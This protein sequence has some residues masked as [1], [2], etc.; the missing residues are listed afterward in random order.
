MSN[1]VFV[2][3]MGNVGKHRDIK[4]LTTEE[5][6]NYLVSETNYRTTIF[7]KFISHRYEKNT[8]I[9]E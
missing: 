5:R 9:Y 2:K 1:A 8:N 7:L 4:L 6:S 3:T